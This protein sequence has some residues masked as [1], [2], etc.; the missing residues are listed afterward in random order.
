M[1]NDRYR[2]IRIRDGHLKILR[3]LRAREE[4]TMISMFDEILLHAWTGFGYGTRDFN[5]INK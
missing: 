2:N 4:R 5:K 1:A 3:A